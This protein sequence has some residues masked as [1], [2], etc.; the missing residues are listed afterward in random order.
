M[1]TSKQKTYLV[2]QLSF[3]KVAHYFALA[4]HNNYDRIDPL[5]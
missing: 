3:A 4:H 1:T 5:N 2:V